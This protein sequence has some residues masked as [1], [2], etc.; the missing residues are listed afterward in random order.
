MNSPQQR[1]LGS[2]S[3]QSS[4]TSPKLSDK[5]QLSLVKKAWEIVRK[6]GK[7]T[8]DAPRKIAKY[9]GQ[10]LDVCAADPAGREQR[11]MYQ[12]AAICRDANHQAFRPNQEKDCEAVMASLAQQVNVRIR[13]AAMHNVVPEMLRLLQGGFGGTLHQLGPDCPPPFGLLAVLSND[14]QVDLQTLDA[15]I[16]NSA[17]VSAAVEAADEKGQTIVSQCKLGN[18]AASAFLSDVLSAR[19]CALAARDRT[20]AVS[21]TA[22]MLLHRGAQLEFQDGQGNAFSS[23]DT[24]S[25]ALNLAFLV[26]RRQYSCLC[27]SCS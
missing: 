25:V 5:D 10:G 24:I 8:D 1:S 14:P 7:S 22:R 21:G 12:V 15:M 19:L 16:S 18:P 17:E 3:S 11:T 9:I 6:L 27:R 4:L 13:Q 20:P 23:E 26:C 2:I